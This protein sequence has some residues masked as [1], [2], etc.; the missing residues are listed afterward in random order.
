V[1][2]AQECNDTVNG[3][4]RERI[5]N[6]LVKCTPATTFMEEEM[7]KTIDFVTQA[8]DNAERAVV[9]DVGWSIVHLFLI[10]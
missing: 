10:K 7:F 5:F 3:S 6:T 1:P 8:D 4:I 2:F 9:C